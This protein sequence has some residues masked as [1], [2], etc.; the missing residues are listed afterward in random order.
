MRILMIVAFALM[1]TPV[2]AETKSEA[3]ELQAQLIVNRD[4]VAQENAR[5]R[6]EGG[7][8]ADFLPFRLGYSDTQPRPLGTA[9]G[10]GKQMGSNN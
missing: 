3:A 7:W 2:T 8:N 4:W 6:A 9:F 5:Y 10:E 1:A